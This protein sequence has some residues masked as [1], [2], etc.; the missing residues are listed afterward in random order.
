MCGHHGHTHLYVCPGGTHKDICGARMY[1]YYSVCV[2]ATDAH[3]YSMHIIYMCGAR[4]YKYNICVPA[5]PQAI[6]LAAAGRGSNKSFPN[7]RGGSKNIAVRCVCIF[8]VCFAPGCRA[9][10][11]F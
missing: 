3:I 9:K 7:A 11:V 8:S 6:Y 4:I 2:R 5:G 1:I 10:T